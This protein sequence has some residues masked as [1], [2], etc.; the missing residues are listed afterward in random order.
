MLVIFVAKTAA[1]TVVVKFRVCFFVC[2]CRCPY[3]RFLFIAALLLLTGAKKQG[4]CGQNNKQIFDRCFIYRGR[5]W[6]R[7]IGRIPRYFKEMHHLIK[8]GYDKSAIWGTCDWFIDTMRSILFRYK[9]GRVST[10]I[11]IKN[12][13]Y[14][15]GTDQDRQIVE[16]NESKW[17]S[18]VERMIELLDDMDEENPI[19]EYEY[20]YDFIKKYEAIEQAKNEFF[21]LFSKYFYE[22]WD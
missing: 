6:Y 8:Y 3:F 5:Y 12:Y 17:N 2:F 14:D 15:I 21:E 13:P 18:I 4:N 9:S 16:D 11:I 10:P 7:N 20:G 22:L 19:Y 1:A